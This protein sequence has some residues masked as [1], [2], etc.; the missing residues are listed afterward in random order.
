VEIE[1]AIGENYHFAL[2]DAL[3]VY[4]GRSNTSFVTRHE[5]MEQNGASPILGP[6]QPLTLSFIDS[7]VRSVRGNTKA[8]ILP[9][10]ILA[11]TDRMIAWWTPRRHRVMFY[12]NSEGKAQSLNGKRLLAAAAGLAGQGWHSPHPR[13][14]REQTSLRGHPPCS[15]SFLEP[16]K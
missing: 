16:L 13:A 15:G 11:K 9:D 4:R 7:L 12:K 5:I 2:H 1:T 3:L 14:G 10:N 6:A 8:E